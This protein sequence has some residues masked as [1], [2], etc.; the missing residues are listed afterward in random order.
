MN[1]EVLLNLKIKGIEK[2]LKL[3]DLLIEAIKKE[4]MDSIASLMKEK[5]LIINEMK[6]I[7][8]KLKK[9]EEW[10]NFSEQSKK[11]FRYIGQILSK[12]KKKEELLLS[13]A[14]K[15]LEEIKI[16][17]DQIDEAIKI[18]ERYKDMRKE[19][20]NIFERVG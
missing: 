17:I 8:R 20:K 7:D 11:K 12:L 14:Q 9:R 18:K 19:R 1:E 13:M 4:Q 2:L 10:R 15:K 16:K 6:D 5:F 3:D